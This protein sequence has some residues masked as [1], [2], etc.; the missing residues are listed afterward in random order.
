MERFPAGTLQKGHKVPEISFIFSISPIIFI[1]NKKHLYFDVE[2]QV[3]LSEPIFWLLA[4][5]SIK[6]YNSTMIFYK[7]TTFTSSVT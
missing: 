2:T 6:S 1:A 4:D 5:F 3:F 7:G